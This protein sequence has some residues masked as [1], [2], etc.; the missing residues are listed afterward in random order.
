MFSVGD[1]V[2]VETRTGRK[3]AGTLKVKDSYDN[4]LLESAVE[5]TSPA[6][7]KTP[8]RREIGTTVVF[9]SSIESFMTTESIS[10]QDFYA[11]S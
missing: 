1:Q 5:I 9:R 8:Q 2:V 10:K 7:S 6:N 4:L 3:I 11:K